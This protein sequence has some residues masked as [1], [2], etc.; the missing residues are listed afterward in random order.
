MDVEITDSGPV[1]TEVDL[2]EAE[3]KV[4]RPIPLAYRQ[5]L[6]AHNG[7]RPASPDFR[8]AEVPKGQSDDAAVK[9]FLGID[10][11]E[12]TLNLQYVFEMFTGRI[13]DDFFPIAFDPGGNLIGI[14]TSGKNEGRVFFWD[15]EHETEEGAPPTHD[16]LYPVADD[17]ETFL[18]KLGEP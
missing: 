11:Q 14:M 1:L 9:R 17:F 5:F 4:G 13:P 15:H 2:A 6:L 10:Q 18:T 8:I 12:P 3:R 7:G 16:N